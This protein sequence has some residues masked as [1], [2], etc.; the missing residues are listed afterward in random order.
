MM[1]SNDMAL[2]AFCPYSANIVNRYETM[3]DCLV[4]YD[5]D[6]EDISN[7]DLFINVVTY[8]AIESFLA[9]PNKRLSSIERK[10]RDVI[11]DRLEHNEAMTKKTAIAWTRLSLIIKRLDE[12]LGDAVH[13]TSNMV[14]NNTY[15][16]VRY[17]SKMD[18]L[19]IT[20]VKSILVT[21][22]PHLAMYPG[23][24]VISNMDTNMCLAYLYEADMAPEEVVDISYDAHM[25]SRAFYEKKI[26]LSKFN[27]IKSMDML[28]NEIQDDRLYL[29]K[30]RV[31]PGR[32][33][34]FPN[35]LK[36]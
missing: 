6:L 20:R 35:K 5:I 27:F 25:V 23:M 15:D 22:T 26:N 28:D 32:R 33:G 34:C 7:D 14:F 17:Q 1:S 18:L 3:L 30:C 19:I 29:S 21:I 13:F 12:I 11:W 8:R 31:C 2:R 9:H 10:F 36:E 24:S 16:G 4:K